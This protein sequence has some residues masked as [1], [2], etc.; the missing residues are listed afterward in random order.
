MCRIGKALVWR[1]SGPEGPCRFES[2]LLRHK[3]MIYQDRIYGEIEIK[4]PVILELVNSKPIQRLKHIEQGGHPLTYYNPRHFPISDIK[5]DRFEHS[6]GVYCLLN[7]FGASLEEQIAGLI[8]DVSHATFSHCIDY[9]LDAGS[10]KEQNH[11]DNI[12]KN[13]V[14]KSEVP[15]ILRKYN[16]ETD[17]ITNEHNFPLLEKP[18]P[19]LCA[20]RL[21]Y[22]LRTAMIFREITKEEFS[23]LLGN[24]TAMDNEWVF[25]NFESAK[26]YAELFLKMN[27]FYFAGINSAVMFRT[28]GDV[29]KH[30]LEKGYISESDL[31]TTDEEVLN[32]VKQNLNDERLNLLFD[33][34]ENK[35]KFENSPQNYDVRVFCKSRI[36]D[37]LFKEDDEI[38]RISDT[39]NDWKEILEREMQP[40]EYFIKFER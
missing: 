20:D 13:F 11:Q 38:K 36:V 5:H 32:K 24:L 26:K 7:K 40:K 16:F 19:D 4:E 10:Q 27:T 30:A 3:F 18:L 23:Y 6:L 1:T 39:D 21:D 22:S 2:C 8:H 29:L 17:Y 35:I 14:R 37:P 25:S 31:Y 34:M 33:R 28:V 15:E 9:V 12:F